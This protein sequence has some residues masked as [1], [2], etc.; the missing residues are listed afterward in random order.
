MDL[1]LL[2]YGISVLG[3]IAP[4]LATIIS[5][6]GICLIILLMIRHIGLSYDSWD[7]E[8]TRKDKAERCVGVDRWIRILGNTLVVTTILMIFIP[9]EKTAYV[10]VGAYATQKVA[11]NEKVQETG[12]K[13]LT[14]IEQKLDSYI[15]EGL[16]EAEKKA[17]HAVEGRDKK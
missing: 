2:V 3:T 16:K 7:S 1:A 10:M 5:F 12:K 13:V 11:E 14:L 17:K 8:R 6:G 15:D 4:L 9:N